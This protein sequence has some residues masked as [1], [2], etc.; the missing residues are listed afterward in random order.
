MRYPRGRVLGVVS[1][2]LL[3]WAAVQPGGA[4]EAGGAADGAEWPLYRGDTAGTGY[5]P[6]VQ[7]TTGNAAS[8]T[9][10]WS[11]SLLAE[12]A[13]DPEAS[14]PRSQA[15]PIVVDGVMYVPAADRVVA[16]EPATGPRALAA[17]GR[18]RRAVAARRGVLAR[19]KRRAA[20]HPVHVRRAAARRRGR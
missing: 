3:V 9:Q 10:A 16:L 2:A 18:G 20:A 15:T 12:G 19:G 7:I 6:L 1:V 14:G 8:L 5:S 17:P 4:Q 11:Y 13:V